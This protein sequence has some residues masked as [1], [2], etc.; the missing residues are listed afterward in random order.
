MK[1]EI[2]SD[3]VDRSYHMSSS[4]GIQ[5]Q[6]QNLK[7]TL[8]DF[9]NSYSGKGLYLKCSRGMGRKLFIQRY[10]AARGLK[11]ISGPI[12]GP[13]EEPC[14][15]WL[16]ANT[17]ISEFHTTMLVAPGALLVFEAYPVSINLSYLRQL[18]MPTDIQFS[19][20][21]LILSSDGD[22]VPALLA[23]FRLCNL[24]VNDLLSVLAVAETESESLALE[25]ESITGRFI[26]A[27]D[28]IDWIAAIR[29]MMLLRSHETGAEIRTISKSVRS[30][31]EDLVTLIAS[32]PALIIDNDSERNLWIAEHLPLGPLTND[33]WSFM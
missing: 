16:R 4:R 12:P 9:I 14:V 33:L 17:T 7:L 19:G 8:K 5:G 3:L 2:K 32:C 25:V 13:V 28:I 21:I 15:C 1:A 6:Y 11:T 24:M 20:G 22:L 18:L 26:D 27:G 30:S 10:A 23:P 29:R 31:L